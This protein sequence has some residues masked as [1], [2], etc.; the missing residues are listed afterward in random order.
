M[1]ET[2]DIPCQRW[3][4]GGRPSWR[5][6]EEG[7]FDRTRYGV[8]EIDELP[9][10]EFV[11]SIHYANTWVA[12][13]RRY[14]MFDLSGGEPRLVGAAILSNP[15]N[16]A[17]LTNVF[18]GLAPYTETADVGRFC[19]LDEVPANAESWF[20]TECC[21]LAA[22]AGYRGLVLF[23]DQVA[24]WTRDGR[25]VKPG[26]FGIA[27]QA[28]GFRF[29]GESSGGVEYHLPDG[30]VICRRSAQ[31]VRGQEPGH[32]YVEEQLIR[33]GAAP[34]RAGQKPA[35]WLAGALPAAGAIPVQ[36]PGK[37]RYVAALGTTRRARRAA[38]REIALPPLPY[39][40]PYLGQLELFTP[41]GRR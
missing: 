41:G 12:T 34:M 35:R 31:K 1:P 9:A 33:W 4:P 39:P 29:T 25:Q 24:R 28:K 37:L 7:G 32:R 2:A 40:K 38:A 23:S 15:M 8:E 26:H 17:V 20:M 6:P 19:L 22:E 5:R 11:L 3:R 27:Y 13:L 18:P 36:H 30:S 10:R 14:G 16:K 21:R